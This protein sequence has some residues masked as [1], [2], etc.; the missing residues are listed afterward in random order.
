MEE[1]DT[2]VAKR[3]VGITKQYIIIVYSC[4]PFYHEIIM[5][6]LSNNKDWSSGHPFIIFP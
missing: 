4:F 3:S 6:K 1:G 5:N 2:Y